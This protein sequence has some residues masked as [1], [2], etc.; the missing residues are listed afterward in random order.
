MSGRIRI[1]SERTTK[2]TLAAR[3]KTT[4]VCI[5][6]AHMQGVTGCTP[7]PTVRVSSF[8]GEFPPGLAPFSP[9]IMGRICDHFFAIGHNRNGK[10]YGLAVLFLVL[11]G[12]CSD[13]P[14]LPAIKVFYHANLHRLFFVVANFDLER[15]CGHALAHVDGVSGAAAFP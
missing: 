10:L 4:E 9:R 12:L 2:G 15:F 11:V 14:A 1:R 5:T 13:L 8:L 3:W 6:T 7:F